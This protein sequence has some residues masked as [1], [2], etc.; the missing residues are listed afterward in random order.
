MCQSLAEG[1]ERCDVHL[2]TSAV[3]FDYTTKT[4]TLPQ[5]EQKAI[6][7][8][9]RSGFKDEPK[10]TQSEY[11]DFVEQ[12]RWRINNTN[13]LSFDEKFKLNQKLDEALEQ[14]LPSGA[15]FAAMQSYVKAVRRVDQLNRK[16]RAAARDERLHQESLARATEAAKLEARR[17][18]ARNADPYD[19]E[20][21]YAAWPIPQASDLDKVSTVIDSI[22]HSATT[23]DS[24]GEAIDVGVRNG[25]YYAN[26][27]GYIGLV[28]KHKDVDGVTHYSLTTAGQ[29]FSMLDANERT[30]MLSSMVNRTPLAKSYRDDPTSIEKEIA[31][32]D[33]SETVAKRRAS[34][35]NTWMTTLSNS[36]SLASSIS[37]QSKDTIARSVEA[38]RKQQI[39]AEKRR[40]ERTSQQVVGQ[41]CTS[42]F[43]V[44]P[45]SNIC[46]TCD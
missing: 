2:K 32:G 27:A 4:S 10:P 36:D 15:G 8:Q 37:Q 21:D 43:M 28:E 1:G 22:N 7:S 44:K 29:T 31:G 39:E 26:A 9:L 38:S 30:A 5:E 41:V 14:N 12:E 18:A 35:L 42:C 45:A 46:P 17:E 16:K 19:N 34:T 6:W 40:Q 3:L 24:I 33:Y 23:A 11:N 13:S 25:S 20:L